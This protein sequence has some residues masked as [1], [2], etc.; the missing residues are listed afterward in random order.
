MFAVPMKDV[1]RP[2]RFL[3]ARPASRCVVG[4]TK[5][6]PRRLGGLLRA[7]R[8]CRGG[9]PED[10]ILR[11]LWLRAVHRG[12]G[13]DGAG[14]QDWSH[15]HSGFQAGIHP[16]PDHNTQGFGST[17]LC[18]TPPSYAHAHGGSFTARAGGIGRSFALSGRSSA[19]NPGRMRCASKSKT[20]SA[21]RRSISNVL[22]EIIGPGR[23]V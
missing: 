12:L 2:A 18:C 13:M 20:S 17:I 5:H 4:Y 16:A 14:A 7:F 19:R 8:L 22:T 23:G 1:V 3:P 10:I 15:D 9:G 11:F 21:S 6:D